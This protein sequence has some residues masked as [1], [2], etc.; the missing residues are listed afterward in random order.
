LFRVDVPI[1]ET[2][3]SVDD[4]IRIGLMITSAG[5]ATVEVGL[6]LDHPSSINAP[7][8][9]PP[10]GSTVAP[11]NDHKVSVEF[12]STPGYLSEVVQSADGSVIASVDASTH[13]LDLKAVPGVSA[14][15]VDQ[16]TSGAWLMPS[17]HATTWANACDFTVGGDNTF[18]G[19]NKKWNDGR[20]IPDHFEFMVYLKNATPSNKIVVVNGATPPG[21][22]DFL[23][24]ALDAVAGTGKSKQFGGPTALWFWLNLS[25]NRWCLKAYQTYTVSA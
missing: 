7:L 20:A 3:D 25:E 9:A 4:V 10:G 5:T 24:L 23:P 2:V 21:G 11:I 8:L 13:K 18:Q 15:V 17:K 16:T 14:P 19:I 22:S 1:A 6:G 12:G